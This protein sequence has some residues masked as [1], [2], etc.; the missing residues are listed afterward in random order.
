MSRSIRIL[1]TAITL[2]IV[3]IAVCFAANPRK[4]GVRCIGIVRTASHS[5]LVIAV[6]QR[7]R[8]QAKSPDGGNRREVPI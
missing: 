7:S 6:F 8:S 1:C 5:C 4:P 2:L 3:L